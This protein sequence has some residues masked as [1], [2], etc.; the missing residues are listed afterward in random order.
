MTLATKNQYCF[1]SLLSLLSNAFFAVEHFGVAHE[2]Q[3]RL[4]ADGPRD[5]VCLSALI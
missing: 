4:F 1:L 5:V 3:Y 2:S